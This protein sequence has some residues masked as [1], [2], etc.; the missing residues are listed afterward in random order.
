[1]K[2]PKIQPLSEQNWLSQQFDPRLPIKLRTGTDGTLEVF[3]NEGFEAYKRILEN[4]KNPRELAR[5][6][7]DYLSGLAIQTLILKFR[8][9]KMLKEEQDPVSFAEKAAIGIA[10]SILPVLRSLSYVRHRSGR[11]R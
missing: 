7:H 4:Q 10:F 5:A 1:M 9:E 6:K 8:A 3:V 2:P 11:S